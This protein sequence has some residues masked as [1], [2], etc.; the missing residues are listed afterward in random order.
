[1]GF[2]LSF[3]LSPDWD[4][5]ERPGCIRDAK[6]N[7][8]KAFVMVTVAQDPNWGGYSDVKL[9]GVRLLACEPVP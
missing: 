5:W 1:M 3:S 7:K 9:E 2:Q 8:C 6:L 4:S